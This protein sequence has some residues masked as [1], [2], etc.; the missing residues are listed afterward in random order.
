MNYTLFK[1]YSLILSSKRPKRKNMRFALIG[2]SSETMQSV[3]AKN[4]L[5]LLEQY[6][7]E[8]VFE[9]DKS[10]DMVI[11]LGGDG[12]FMRA[13]H[14]VGSSGIPIVGINLGHLGFL[15]DVS[16]DEIE[17]FLKKVHEGR[18]EVR[19][20][21]VLEIDIVS[22]VEETSAEAPKG[23]SFYA[24]NEL[25]VMKHDSASV[26]CVHTSVNGEELISYQA[27]GLL[28]AT[29]TGSTAYSL[30]A[31][32]PIIHPQSAV[33]V[34]TA[35][36]PHSLNMR[37]IILSDD[38]EIVLNVESRTGRFLI[39]VDGESKSYPVGTSVSVKK[40][41]FRIKVVKQEGNTY[42]K[43]LQEKMM[44]GVSHR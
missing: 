26:I 1:D 14:K 15:A 34:L 5:R 23:E 33:F 41:P 18:Y 28:V 31:G 40:A 44:W 25:S 16:A 32:G 19:E 2:T 35:V 22:P 6:G 30:S 29:P 4:L 11:S 10:V 8:I 17:V 9:V 43:T 37:P 13:A 21:S 7:D 39:A 36:A 12:T 27:D 3:Q 42:F 20:R 24:L 38:K